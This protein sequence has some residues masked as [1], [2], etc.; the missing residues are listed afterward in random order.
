MTIKAIVRSV[1]L[2]VIDKESVYY[3]TSMKSMPNRK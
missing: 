1:I 2:K 3:K